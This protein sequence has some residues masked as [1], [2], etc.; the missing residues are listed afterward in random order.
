MRTW[1]FET[2]MS[3]IYNTRHTKTRDFHLETTRNA[4]RHSDILKKEPFICLIQSWLLLTATLRNRTFLHRVFSSYV[5]IYVKAHSTL[6][7]M[8]AASYNTST[9][10]KHG[11]F[12]HSVHL[13]RNPITILQRTYTAYWYKPHN[14]IGFL[15]SNG[16]CREFTVTACIDMIA[17][18]F[19]I[20]TSFRLVNS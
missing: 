17:Q 12:T 13:S 20:V 18:V 4:V 8:T 5:T 15:V 19:W 16:T 2:K 3:S 9:R 7:G 6:H 10:C 11:T 14:L 1:I